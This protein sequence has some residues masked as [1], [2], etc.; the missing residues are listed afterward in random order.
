MADIQVVKEPSGIKWRTIV[1]DGPLQWLVKPVVKFYRRSILRDSFLVSVKKWKRDRG[2]E[3]LRMN[4][5]LTKDSVVLDVGGYVG[6]FASAMFEKFGCRVLVFEPMRRF[7]EQC[8]HRFAQNDAVTVFN[9]GLGAADEQLRLSD[10][11]DASSFCREGSS[12]GTVTAQ[13]RDIGAVW[14]E[15]GIEQIDLMKI[16]IEGGEYSLLRRMLDLGLAEKVN[17]F[18]VQFHNFVPDA[19]ELREDLRQRL[20][21]THSE[22]WCYDFV[23][24]NWQHR[25]SAA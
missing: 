8:E 12:G 15:L 19:V 11:A 17:N 25:K 24:E 20:T 5:P 10:S 1:S 14:R 3:R 13:L 16:N 18:Q 4:Y 2:D 21:A 22:D 6:D 9:F 7:Y 23:W